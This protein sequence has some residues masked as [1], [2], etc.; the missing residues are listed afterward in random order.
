MRYYGGID[1]LTA[2]RDEVLPASFDHKIISV[3]CAFK[4]LA[5]S[6]YVAIGVIGVKDRKRFLLNVVNTHLDA[7]ATEAEI[8]HQRE[9][10]API[11]A[12]LIEDRANG[13]A[14]IQRLKANVTGVIEIEP[15]GGKIARMYAA[16]PEWQAQDWYV[17]RNAAWTEPFIQQVTMFPTARH[18]DMAD[19][20]S[21]ASIW[22][23]SHF[24]VYGLLDY[25]AGIV[26]GVYSL[27][28]TKECT[29]GDDTMNRQRELQLEAKIINLKPSTP[30]LCQQE[31]PPCPS[32]HAT[33][34][35][36]LA[37]QFH[38]NQCSHQWGDG[39]LKQQ[40]APSRHDIFSGRYGSIRNW[41]M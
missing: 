37:E 28:E 13:S 6:D 9:Q 31:T 27:P 38:C 24:H 26:K 39:P 23:Q 3:D 32:C 41:R 14:V 35:I 10:H 18:D 25:F 30:E 29:S 33:C 16:A 11:N 2:Q 19:M 7:A 21:Q 4:D 5:T 1:P 40:S 20:M 8:R 22:L 15:Q 34:V 36:K 12:V 17:E